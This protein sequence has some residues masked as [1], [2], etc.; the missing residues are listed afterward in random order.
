MEK[1]EYAKMTN[2]SLFQSLNQSDVLAA[3]YFYILLVT[4]S[5][6]LPTYTYRQAFF[7]FLLRF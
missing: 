2:H 4:K 1:K 6:Q 5:C 3:S 7:E